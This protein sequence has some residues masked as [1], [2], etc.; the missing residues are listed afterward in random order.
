MVLDP[1]NG[2][3]IAAE[4]SSVASSGS[5][6]AGGDVISD[7]YLNRAIGA[8]CT[9]NGRL[10]VSKHVKE[11][12]ARYAPP[13]RPT[14]NWIPQ[15]QRRQFLDELAKITGRALPPEEPTKAEPTA[16]MLANGSVP[17]RVEAGLADQDAR[18]IAH[19]Y[20]PVAVVG[21][22]AVG[23]GWTT[24]PSTI[25]A[26]TAERAD[27]P[28]AASTGLRTGRLVGIDIDIVPAEHVQAI[29]R[30][31]AECLGSALLER[32][33]AKGAMLCYRNETP[34]KK[35]TV[36]GNHPT[37]PGKVEILGIGQH[38]VAY[39]I[40]PD[41]GR[42]YTWTNSL[43]VGEPLQTPV[44][45]LPEVTADC[46]RAFA[47]RAAALMAS[48]GYTD[49]KVSS[50]GEAAERVQLNAPINP[51][52][53]TPDSLDRA[54]TWLQSLIERG[55]VAIEGRGG[56]D[57]TYQVACGL[58]D[59]GLSPG[60]ALELLLEPGGWDEHC[61]PPW[62][63]GRARRQGTQRL[64]IRAEPARRACWFPFSYRTAPT[65]HCRSDNIN[66]GRQAR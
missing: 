65:R 15:E 32:V 35:I 20:E 52:F 19:G 41:T 50:R 1:Y 61:R 57:R 37:Q 27:R 56:D 23:K 43:L 40:H 17:I 33:G 44:D 66:P 34:I 14:M 46:L 47:E 51:E 7:R 28:D 60:A 6:H 5:G 13:E 53:D 3:D 2:D 16:K 64:Q 38:F 22:A 54:R 29:K 36:S 26:V 49:V 39:G 4:F 55:E 8:C 59:V 10:F 45:K 25:E 18:L 12:I 42:P 24:R 63:A 31:A 62:G 11:L 21:K 30:L 48:L 58:R 9:D